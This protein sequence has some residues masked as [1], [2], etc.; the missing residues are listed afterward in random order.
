[1]SSKILLGPSSFAE[2]DKTPVERLQ[3]A[4]FEVIANPY[5]RKLTK[6]ELLR[7]LTPDVVG[8]IAGLEPLDREV[9]SQSKL[10]GISRVGAGLT[11]V[12]LKAAAELGIDVRYTPDGPTEAVAELTVGALLSLL[13]MIPAMDR[14]LHASKWDKRIGTQL[15]DKTVAIIGYGRIG[16]RVAELLSPFNV[17]LLAVDPYPKPPVEAELVS[18]DEALAKADIISLHCS[19]ESC[20]LG[21]REFQIMKRGAFLLNVARGGMIAEDALISALEDG[22]LAGVWLDTFCVEPYTGALCS[23]EDVLLTP[24]VGSYTLECR[25]EMECEAVQNLL[26]ILGKRV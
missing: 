12:D 16:R 25:L 10:K 23:R 26:H 5:R 2:I 22:R 18:L 19:G 11:N 21:E 24:H 13:R 1:M 15:K 7:L 17:R 3:D 6:L 4:G 14:A 20:L 9:L 8:I